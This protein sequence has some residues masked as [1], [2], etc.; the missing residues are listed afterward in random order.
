MPEWICAG[1]SENPV[2]MNR[3]ISIM[4]WRSVALTALSVPGLCL[5]L[6]PALAGHLGANPLEMLLHRTGEISVWTLGAVL[7]LTPLR[8]L[9][10][11][12]RIIAAL[13]QHRRAIGVSAFIYGLLHF[14]FHILYE[15]GLDGLTRSLS[16]P[17]IWIGLVGLSLLAL[18]A[19][20]SNNLAIRTLGGR[21]WKRLHRLAYLAGALLIYHQS[22][23]GKGH[24][25]IAR[26]LLFPLASLQI[27]RLIKLLFMKSNRLRSPTFVAPAPSSP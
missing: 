25:H 6:I 5:L 24:W 2:S 9:F 19:A 27:G 21:N 4:R 3:L 13:N 8:V 1:I 20:T 14:A 23:A 22:I 7:S 16:K 17:F 15:G 11:S 18:L 12:S 10:S 26:W